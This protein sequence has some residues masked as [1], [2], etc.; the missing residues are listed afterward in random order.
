MYSLTPYDNTIMFE[1]DVYQLLKLS[2]VRKKSQAKFE[3][4]LYWLFNCLIAWRV[5]PLISVFIAD[6]PM[7]LFERICLP[8]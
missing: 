5:S 1:K 7:H 8:L 3:E 2:T 6:Y 4:V